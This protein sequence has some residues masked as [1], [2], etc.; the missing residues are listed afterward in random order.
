[1]AFGTIPNKCFYH[2]QSRVE[3]LIEDGNGTFQ[4]I[5]FEEIVKVY[6]SRCTLSRIYAPTLY[7]IGGRKKKRLQR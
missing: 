5:D 7:A 2:V 4:K 6:T 1:M 3:V